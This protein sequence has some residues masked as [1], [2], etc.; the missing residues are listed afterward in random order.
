MIKSS[1][2]D[3]ELKI[4]SK[5]ENNFNRL[6][7]YLHLSGVFEDFVDVR[8][9]THFGN[10]LGIQEST[11]VTMELETNDNQFLKSLLE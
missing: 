9:K 11:N 2:F 5:I 10:D 6:Q 8:H 1:S 4:F 7:S 3:R